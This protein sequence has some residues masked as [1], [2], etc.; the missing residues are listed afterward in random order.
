MGQVGRGVG[1]ES[2]VMKGRE[3]GLKGGKWEM[4]GGGGGGGLVMYIWIWWVM[5]LGWGG[6]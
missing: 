1:T 6:R 4:E 3:V 5:R 2:D